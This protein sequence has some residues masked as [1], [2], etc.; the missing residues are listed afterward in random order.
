MACKRSSCC[1]LSSAAALSHFL[2]LRLQELQAELGCLRQEL[3]AARE[4]AGAWQARCTALQAEGDGRGLELARADLQAKVCGRLF[5]RGPWLSGWVRGG[6][7]A[8][9]SWDGTAGGKHL[10]LDPALLPHVSPRPPAQEL[11]DALQLLTTRADDEAAAAAADRRRLE[12]SAK[13]LEGR[14]AGVQ[15]ELARTREELGATEEGQA[16]AQAELAA[17]QD[18]CARLR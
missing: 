6:G 14:L 12:A 4:E 9:C 16:T 5:V 7:Q 15:A 18:E 1:C 8:G 11:S 13:A 2:P 3:R 17:A 10:V